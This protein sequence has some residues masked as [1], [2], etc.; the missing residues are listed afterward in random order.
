[1]SSTPSQGGV[2]WRSAS[3][4]WRERDDLTP[5]GANQNHSM[6]RSC[7]W[8]GSRTN[9]I[10]NRMAESDV[11]ARSTVSA[12]GG[13]SRISPGTDRGRT[14]GRYA[15]AGGVSLQSNGCVAWRD[16]RDAFRFISRMRR[17]DNASACA[18][19]ADDATSG[20]LRAA[21]LCEDRKDVLFRESDPC[22]EAFCNSG[23][24]IDGHGRKAL[25]A[26][27]RNVHRH[28]PRRQIG[29]LASIATS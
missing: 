14:R 26:R 11:A 7:V 15:R 18:R 13:C 5:D 19:G 12:T 20:E 22:W 4:V 9:A 2:L 24:K 21:D 16:G 28:R 10:G 17:A 8:R 29:A 23:R 3:G 6:V 1:M 25:R 27:N